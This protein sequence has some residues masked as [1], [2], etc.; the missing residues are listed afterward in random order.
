[1]SNRFTCTMNGVSPESLD[2]AIRVTD[3][4][5][6]SPRMRLQTQPCAGHGLRLLRQVRESLTVRISLI[7]AEYDPAARRGA[8]QKLNVWA[9][10]GGWLTV[11]DRPGQRLRI[12]CCTLPAMCALGWTDEIQLE[13]TACTAPFWETEKEYAAVVT[14]GGALTLPGSAPDCPVSC[15]VV[16]IGDGPLSCVTLVCGGTSM[17]FEGLDVQ[18]GETLNVN[19]G[20]GGVLSATTGSLSV[21]MRRTP[22]SHDLLLADG[23]ASTAVAVDADQRVS[24]AFRARGRYV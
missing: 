13:C 18:P 8:L 9:A 21:L 7:I 15:D 10:G 22:G 16:N 24:A 14:S 19:A 17:T 20:S 11:S 1:M 23:G 3:L 5:E 4:T 2:P 6:L 12:D